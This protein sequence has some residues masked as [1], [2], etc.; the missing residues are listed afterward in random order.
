MKTIL[1][2]TILLLSIIFLVSSCKSDDMNYSDANI[3]PVNKLYEPTDGRAIK[4]LSSATASL[5]FEWEAS[6]AEDSGSP[7][8][9][10][11]FDKE[12]GDFSSP[13]FKVVSDNSGFSGHATILH[14]DLNKI[15]G[16]AGIGAQET[17]TVIWT[18]VSSR[19]LN[20]AKA[21][22]SRKLVITRLAGFTEIPDEVFI[23]GEGSEAGT[24]LSEAL[25]LKL[26]AIGEFEI[27]TKLTAGK[28]YQFIDRKDGTPR[29]FY[30]DGAKLVENGSTTAN[31]TG[32]YRVNLDYNTGTGTLT[33]IKSIGLFFCPTNSVL[34]NLDYVGKGIFTGQGN[35]TFKQEGWGRDQ[36]YKFQ[37]ESVNSS[38]IAVTQQWGTKNG[39]DEPPTSTSP[40]S[41]FYVKIV[42]LDQ[43]N[44][45]W[46][47]TSEM[48]KAVVSISM[49]LQGDKEYTHTVKKVSNL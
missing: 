10:V 1:N 27:Y 19:G 45:K 22:E 32:V 36:R 9:E 2:N 4:L 38:G 43:W 8:Y 31:K 7:L 37:M 49:Y 5:F 28:T 18:V 13:I 40:E 24:N 46:K 26:N 12:G 20:E 42:S 33:E 14:K 25:P 39:T 16:L 30:I 35:V 23:T 17:G 48:D 41:Y 11:V 29:T 21:K 15:A 44:D 47:F 34:F 6:K 3:T